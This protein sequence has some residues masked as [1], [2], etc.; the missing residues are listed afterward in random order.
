MLIG[1]L[2]ALTTS[3]FA[4]GWAHDTAAPDRVV[5]VRLSGPEDQ[6][7]GFGLANLHRPDLA[8]ASLHSGWCAFRLRLAL[9][10]TLETLKGTRLVLCET[11]DGTEIWAG[12][13]WHIRDSAEAPLD[14][15]EHVAAQDPT[16]VAS[17]QQLSACGLIF[18]NFIARHGAAEF[19]RTACLYVLGNPADDARRLGWERLLRSG[20][21]TPFGLLALLAET[22]E[23]R[24]DHRL[25]ASPADPGFVFAA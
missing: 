8:E 24:R 23:A 13:E 21:I 7:F 11:A 2:D 15:P 19:V 14:T 17:V 16:T 25:L 3:G 18:C 5:G 1:H 10:C 4:E 22:E 12:A 9:P 6:E 20:A